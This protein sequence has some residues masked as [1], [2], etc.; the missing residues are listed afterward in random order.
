MIRLFGKPAWSR[1]LWMLVR[2][3]RGLYKYLR[4]YIHRSLFTFFIYCTR[5]TT[6]FPVLFYSIFTLVL[7][8]NLSVYLSL[9]VAKSRHYGMIQEGRESCLVL[10]KTGHFMELRFKFCH[11][12]SVLENGRVQGSGP[13]GARGLYYNICER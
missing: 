9:L 6:S 10:V 11:R 5:R 1:T 3:E 7:K 13:G 4:R 8:L 12:S 2:K